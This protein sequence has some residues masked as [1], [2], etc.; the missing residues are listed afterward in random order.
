MPEISLPDAPQIYLPILKKL[1][2]NHAKLGGKVV[3]CPC[4]YQIPSER[5]KFLPKEITPEKFQRLKKQ[6]KIKEG[7]Y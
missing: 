6:M 2:I 3:L 5:I 4:C 7:G 1:L